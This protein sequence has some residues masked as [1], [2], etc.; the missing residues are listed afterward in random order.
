MRNIP[1][2]LKFQKK[3][4]DYGNYYSAKGI[5]DFLESQSPEGRINVN[6]LISDLCLC[7]ECQ[8]EYYSEGLVGRFSPYFSETQLFPEVDSFSVLV[9]D[10]KFYSYLDYLPCVYTQ[11]DLPFDYE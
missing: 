8:H 4:T 1:S 5:E 6:F 10:S 3:L 9:G 2:Y 7:F 11:L